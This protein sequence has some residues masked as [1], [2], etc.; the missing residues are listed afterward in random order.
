[1][2]DKEKNSED[3][4]SLWRKKTASELDKPSAIGD[5]LNQL[6]KIKNENELLRLKINDNIEL[7]KNSESVL[8]NAVDERNKFKEDKGQI[9]NEFNKK[10]ENLEWLL[11]QKD[12]EVELK[13]KQIMNKDYEIEEMKKKLNQNSSSGIP[14]SGVNKSLIEDLQSQLSKKK[15]EIQKFTEENLSLK[16]KITNIAS[17]D[18]S[19]S[20]ETLC[21]DLQSD[22]N[23]YK[24]LADRLQVENQQLQN[25]VN[26]KQTSEKIDTEELNTL[27][28]DNQELKK[29]ISEL[30]TFINRNKVADLKKKVEDN[31]IIIKE[32]KETNKSL[33]KIA[34]GAMKDLIDELQGRINK[35]K[36]AVNDRDRKIKEMQK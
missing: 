30:E 32:L 36:I 9:I 15:S 4:L 3:F 12:E 21:Q 33:T 6:E 24:S 8:K 7:I 20:L 25:L 1:M 18:G 22:L 28:S 14:F 34:P 19:P 26:N 13:I 5:A 2:S 35:L 17:S 29:R 16:E 10:I 27:R 31:K 23:R 11:K